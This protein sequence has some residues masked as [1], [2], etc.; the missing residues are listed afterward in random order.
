MISLGC[1]DKSS[2][3]STQENG[4]TD[5]QVQ[6]N[7]TITDGKNVDSESVSETD[8]ASAADGEHISE[9]DNVSS[10]DN[11]SVS[12]DDEPTSE[13]VNDTSVTEIFKIGEQKNMLGVNIKLVDITDYDNNTA[14]ISI[15]NKQYKYSPELEDTIK[16]KAPNGKNIDILDIST[17]KEDKTAEIT[18]DYESVSDNESTNDSSS[19]GVSDEST[20]SDIVESTNDTSVTETFNIGDQKNM[21]GADIKLIKIIDFNSNAVTLDINNTE[22]KYDPSSGEAL[23]VE[24]NGTTIEVVDL[25]TVEE[26]NTVEI[27][28]DYAKK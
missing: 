27:T 1:V 6:V 11:E 15:D 23:T 24:V 12:T 13:V 14:T 26:N 19:T 4:T 22:Y 7:P 16:A 9:N 2:G 3:D 28:V 25:V 10:E 21:L 20:P 17:T 5:E 18:V 8:N